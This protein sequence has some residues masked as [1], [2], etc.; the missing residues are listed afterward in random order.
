MNYNWFIMNQKMVKSITIHALDDKLAQLIDE[1]AGR[2]GT[3]LNQ[4]IKMLL[5]QSLGI[6]ADSAKARAAN[7]KDMLG[8]WSKSDEKAFYSKA[9]GFE[10]VDREDW[11]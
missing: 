7:F 1:K 4:T 3:S 8:V 11:P 2:Q 6:A 9:A 10:R 5:R